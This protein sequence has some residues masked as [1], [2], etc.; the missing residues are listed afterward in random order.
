MMHEELA[1]FR[2]AITAK[3]D[4]HCSLFNQEKAD[5]VVSRFFTPDAIWS[6]QGLPERN[7]RT[8]LLAM[9]RE[10][11]KTGRIDYHSLRSFVRG[12]CG[13][14]YCD[15]YVTPLDS[16]QPGWCFRT[17]FCWVLLDEGWFCNAVN[18]YQ[19]ETPSVLAEE[20]TNV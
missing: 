17:L 7:G 10:V 15:W 3:Y 1:A 16:E 4:E 6:G 8:E 11:V 2:A 19:A 12:G 13:W 20:L 9:F 5:S 14:D 18:C